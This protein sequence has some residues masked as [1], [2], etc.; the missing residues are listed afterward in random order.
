MRPIAVVLGPNTLVR[1]GLARILRVANFRVL[2][3]ASDFDNALL[4]SLLRP[5]S[6]LLVVHLDHDVDHAVKLIELFKERQPNGRVAVLA[7][8]CDPSHVVS[9]LR[10]QANAFFVRDTTLDAFIKSLELVMLGEII[11]PG[12]ILPLIVGPADEKWTPAH[13]RNTAVLADAARELSVGERRVLRCLV[14]G[15]PNKLIARKCDITEATVKVHVQA[16]LQKIRVRNRTQAAIWALN[17]SVLSSSADSAEATGA[18]SA[19]NG[20]PARYPPRPPWDG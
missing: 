10:A 14:D 2:T 19:T 18:N 11:L 16:I 12:E 15:D 7:D 1:E 20:A 4:S 8:R 5:E 13:Q 17:N 6:V 9:V 3:S